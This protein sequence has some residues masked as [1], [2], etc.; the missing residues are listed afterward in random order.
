MKYAVRVEFGRPQAEIRLSCRL[1]IVVNPERCCAVALYPRAAMPQA[2]F[3]IVDRPRL[4]TVPVLVISASL[5]IEKRAAL[6]G[7]GA[8]LHKP[9][10]PKNLFSMIEPIL[11][12]T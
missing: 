4:L 8:F 10:E 5:G 6:A 1:A 9:V 2:E 7:A 11:D 12:A 3:R